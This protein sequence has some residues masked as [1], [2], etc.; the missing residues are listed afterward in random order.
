M[1]S[2]LKLMKAANS[3]G[4]LVKAIQQYQKALAHYA[5]EAHWAVAGDDDLVHAVGKLA[6]EM[7]EEWRLKNAELMDAYQAASEKVPAILWLGDDDPTMA[8]Q[9]TLGMRK[10]AK[11]TVREPDKKEGE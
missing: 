1:A 3:K 6:V 5:N 10:V 4:T 7:G 9:V 11:Q 2:P 8:A